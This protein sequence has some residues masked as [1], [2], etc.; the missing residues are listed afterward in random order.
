MKYIFRRNSSDNKFY[1]AAGGSNDYAYNEDRSSDYRH[2]NHILSAYAGYTLRYKDFTFKPGLRYEQTI[3]RVKYIVGPG[4]NFHTNFSDLVPS[5]SLGMKIGKT[6]NIRAGYNMRIWRPGI[7]KN[8]NTGLSL[9]LNWNASPKTR[10][11]VNGRGSYTD[12]KS[13]AQGLHNYGW[14]G[15]FYGGIQHTLPLKLRLSLNGGG[16]TPYIS[17]QG[18][19]SGYQYYGLS[20]N[21]SFL[22]EDR[23][24][25]N[26]YC[27]NIF[28]KYR[29]YNNHTEGANFVS[30]SS[31][32]WP[33]R[34]FGVSVS[35]RIGEL[36]A[37]VKKAAR[38]ISNDD[39]KGGG[40]GGNAG[41]GG[42]Q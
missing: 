35:Y 4:E 26:L 21:R 30:K 38:S 7:G 20:L 25:V 18:K 19:G 8:R 2:L 41:G 3:Q 11:Y 27:N 22:K 34:S 12:M 31:S 15:S 13:E 36:K 24:S 16:S 1:E 17:L 42:G 9:Y 39:V 33:S 10:I 37:S 23:L 14:N 29:S 6:Q 28:E 40:G 5:V 32:K